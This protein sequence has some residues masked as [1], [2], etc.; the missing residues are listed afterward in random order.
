MPHNR[1]RQPMADSCSH[2]D[3]I[4]TVIPSALGCEECLKIGSPWVHLRIC[5]TCGHVGCC[6]SSPNRHA[7]KHFH[8]T[9]HPIIEGYDPPEGWGWCYVDEV[10]FDLSDRM[11]PHNGP[12]PRYVC[13]D[14]A[15]VQDTEGRRTSCL[16]RYWNP[17]ASPSVTASSVSRSNVP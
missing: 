13:L 10:T 3:T 1:T 14:T 11:T 15:L 2:L 16:M 9:G 5:R 6:D 8:R 4:R 7:T 12:I 17:I